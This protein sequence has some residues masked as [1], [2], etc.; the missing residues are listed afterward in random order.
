MF[1][2]FI[3]GVIVSGLFFILIG[4]MLLV[5][6]SGADIVDKN[7]MRECY[8]VWK[9]IRRLSADEREIYENWCAMTDRSFLSD[10][11]LMEWASIR[12][13][14]GFDNEEM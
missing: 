7:R 1:W 8:S 12:N 6:L 5:I 10:T 4:Y 9:R 13:K 11:S 14:F 3:A 2:S